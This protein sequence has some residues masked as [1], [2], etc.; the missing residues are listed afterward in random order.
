[1]SSQPLQWGVVVPV[2]RLSVAKTRLSTRSVHYRRALAYAFALDVVAACLDSRNVLGVLVVADDTEVR[3]GMAALG[4]DAITDGPG[5][6]GLNPA[7]LLGWSRLSVDHPAAGVALLAADLPALRP[8]DLTRALSAAAEHPRAFVSDV[9]GT[10]TTLLTCRPGT[11]PNPRFG[12][13]SRAAHTASGAVEIVDNELVRL[14]T[15]VDTEVDLWHAE[16]LGVGARTA[17]VLRS[18]G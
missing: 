14:R 2:K 12:P 11:A 16:V 8:R 9:A 6:A 1:M 13:R 10:G 7:L 4:A 5:D 18:G 15:D 17:A 3:E